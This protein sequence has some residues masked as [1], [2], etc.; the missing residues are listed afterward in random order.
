ML[1]CGAAVFGAA[2]LLRVGGVAITVEDTVPYLT[3]KVESGDTPVAL[4]SDSAFGVKDG[5]SERPIEFRTANTSATRFFRIS[6]M[7]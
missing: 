6:R 4:A 7:E 1:L 3:Y 5:A 2:E